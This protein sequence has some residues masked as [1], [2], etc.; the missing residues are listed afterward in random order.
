MSKLRFGLVV[1]APVTGSSLKELARRAEDGGY[2]TLLFP[3]HLDTPAPLPSLA[4]AAAAT[5]VLRVGTLVA[6]NGLRHPLALAHEIATADVLSGGRVELG[7]G[8]GHRRTEHDVL[9]LDFPSV[10]ERVARLAEAAQLVR[11]LCSGEPT[12]FRG[13][14]YDVVEYRLVPPPIQGARLPL[15]LG[16]NSTQLL[17]MA[18]QHA[19]ILQFTGLQRGSKRGTRP[20]HLTDQ[21]LADRL[22]VVRLAAGNRLSRLELSI[23]IQHAIVTEEPAAAARRVVEQTEWSIDPD[24]LL[25]SPFLLLGPRSR[26]ME[27]LVSCRER[28][29]ISY[30]TVFASRSEKFDPVVRALG[31]T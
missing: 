8:A 7:L 20:S 1:D 23:A 14:Y 13:G 29:G 22:A 6:N 21:G 15:L 9:G 3:D 30:F 26:I 31:E 4:T 17:T 2:S 16:G 10:D 27:R 24:R 18:A 28:F 12:S 19:D 11:L 25:E 5:S